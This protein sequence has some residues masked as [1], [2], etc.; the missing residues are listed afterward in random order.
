M[1]GTAREALRYLGITRAGLISKFDLCKFSFG[2]SRVGD[3]PRILKHGRM[4]PVRL[5]LFPKVQVGHEL[6]SS[7]I[8][9]GAVE[10][11]VVFQTG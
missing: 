7:G 1:I 5:N 10:R 9:S 4:M 3:M 11:G 6:S 2:Y 8:R